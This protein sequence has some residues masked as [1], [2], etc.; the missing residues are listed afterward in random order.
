MPKTR[1]RVGIFN[2]S[3]LDNTVKSILMNTLYQLKLKTR[4]TINKRVR[5]PSLKQISKLL[6]DNGIEHEFY[7]SQNVV[8]HR[9]KG[10]RYVNSRYNG[11][12]GYVLII[13]DPYLKM[14]TSDSYY[15]YNSYFYAIELLKLIEKQTK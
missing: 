12:K 11:K 1:N 4:Q 8:E 14:D 15:S 9:T 10:H 13:R 6:I 2:H 5:M 7:E 3:A